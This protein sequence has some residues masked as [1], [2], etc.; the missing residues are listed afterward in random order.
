MSDLECFTFPKYETKKIGGGNYRLIVLDPALAHYNVRKWTG[1]RGA[2]EFA[3]EQ[4]DLPAPARGRPAGDVRWDD[5]IDEDVEGVEQEGDQWICRVHALPETRGAI[6]GKQGQRRKRLEEANQVRIKIPGPDASADEPVVITAPMKESVLSAKAEV[7]III[8]REMD[9]LPYTHF[10]SLPLTGGDVVS[11]VE[12]WQ[13]DAMRRGYRSIDGSLFMPARRLHFTVCMLRLHTQAQV[14][15]CAQLLQSLSKDIYDAVNTRTVLVRLKGLFILNDDPSSVDVVY[16]GDREKKEVQ[17]RIN[18]MCDVIFKALIHEGLTSPSELHRQRLL[19]TS[20]TS[21]HLNLHATLINTKY[22]Y[23]KAA[24]PPPSPSPDAEYADDPDCSQPTRGRTNRP[25]GRGGGPPSAM[26]P[27]EPIDA[28]GLLRDFANAVDYGE[29]RV[30]GVHLSR[31]DAFDE[32][33]YYEKVAAVA[34][35]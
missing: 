12:K 22:R 10:I 17:Q 34:L 20:G 30:P 11:R 24:V 14:D 8:E 27:G 23:K 4:P 29:V 19:D 7:E 5:E 13:Q 18:A 31:L 33:G 28:T 25:R 26:P 21:A 6:V 9:R 16:T 35:P 15:K 32:S 1:R 3:G 2:S